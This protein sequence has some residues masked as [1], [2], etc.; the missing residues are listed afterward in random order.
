MGIVAQATGITF[1]WT[2]SFGQLVQIAMLIAG[3]WVAAS[4]LYYAVD[5]RLTKV[6]YTIET[7]ANKLSGVAE[8]T[9]EVESTL[10]K[11]VSDLARVVGALDVA[12]NPHAWDGVAERRNK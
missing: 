6:E 1:D 8:K 7:Q 12:R 11:T 9:G 2:I 4:K 5:R 3:G 10:V